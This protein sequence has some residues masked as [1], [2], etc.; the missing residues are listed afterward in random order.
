MTGENSKSSLPDGKN[1]SAIQQE[2][3]SAPLITM[4]TN[5]TCHAESGDIHSTL[6]YI[7]NLKVNGDKKRLIRI[8]EKNEDIL[9]SRLMLLLLRITFF[10]NFL[11]KTLK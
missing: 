2:E 11:K 10:L 8:D 6:D 4:E 9:Y 5:C 1:I 7:K 3:I